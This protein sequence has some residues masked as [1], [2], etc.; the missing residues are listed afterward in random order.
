MHI[1]VELN[2]EVTVNNVLKCERK[3]CSSLIVFFFCDCGEKEP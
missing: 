1:N 2:I 3:F